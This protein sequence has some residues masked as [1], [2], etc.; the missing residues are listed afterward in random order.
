MNSL[1]C[2]LARLAG[3]N[4]AVAIRLAR[5][6]KAEFNYRLEVQTGVD[7]FDRQT[8]YALIGIY[9]GMLSLGLGA[10]AFLLKGRPMV[11]SFLVFTVVTLTVLC[12]FVYNLFNDLLGEEDFQIISVWP[13]SS[14]TY[15]YSKLLGPA[16]SALLMTLLLAGPTS[17]A[18]CFTQ[19]TPLFTGITILLLGCVLSVSLVAWLACLFPLLIRFVGL[20]KLRMGII[21]ILI[22]TVLIML[23]VKDYPSIA[24]IHF[25][26][27]PMWV[28]LT[29]L[30]GAVQATVGW[31]DYSLS[32][33]VLSLLFFMVIPI[34]IFRVTA[35]NFRNGI[36]TGQA[37]SYSGK[38]SGFMTRLKWLMKRAEDRILYQLLLAHARGDWRFRVQALLIYVVPLIFAILE[39]RGEMDAS[40]FRDPMDTSGFFHPAMTMM[41]FIM[42]PPLLALPLLSTSSDFQ[43]AWIL[44][45][46][47]IE[48]EKF[49]SAVVRLVRRMFT[50][51]LLVFFFGF[52]LYQGTS[53]LS[54]LG[55]LF[56]LFILA[57][58]TTRAVQVFWKGTP[59]SLDGRDE[60]LLNRSFPLF[61][62]YEV[63]SALAAVFVFH[64]AYRWWWAY[65][66]FC[67]LAF[68]MLR[69]LKKEA[70]TILDDTIPN[71][72][73]SKV[74]PHQRSQPQLE[75]ALMTALKNGHPHLARV[76]INNGS[77]LGEKDSN[78]TSLLDIAKE[79]GLTQIVELI[80]AEKHKD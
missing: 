13:V 68:I 42:F 80:Q 59:F 43:A 32:F 47:V 4:G 10:C 3:A 54:V 37:S 36:L 49:R 2:F 16:R 34:F 31:T 1:V 55:H 14:Q 51:P 27:L 56:A 22:A 7:G 24:T 9:L 25:I 20:Q 8:L 29:W 15:L 6:F 69:I 44:N 57:E 38:S 46:G 33:L 65:I 64:I 23:M 11:Y 78:G 76:L 63:L 53:V 60:D 17:I 12:S 71:V 19:G 48:G 18:A 52:Y 79:K 61:M 41:V 70:D 26:Q 50:Y 74:D 30:A 77:D 21:Y 72:V 75:S 73:E 45:M 66:L 58:F 40:L 39:F 28:P 5:V 62:M 67:A 35:E